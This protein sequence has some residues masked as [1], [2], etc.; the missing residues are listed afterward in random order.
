[1]VVMVVVV[2][3][4]SMRAMITVGVTRRSGLMVLVTVVPQLCLVK[5]KEE[6]HATEQHAKELMRAGL[7]LKGLGQ[8]MQKRCAHERAGRQT[9]H[10]LGVA[11]Q[12]GKAQGCSKPHAAHPCSDGTDQNRDQ[13]HCST[14][15]QNYPLHHPIPSSQPAKPIRPG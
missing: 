5:Q 15:T 13:C 11:R 14:T 8:K 1:M 2:M 6:H 4:L 7:T 12:H 9:E 3:G 10:V